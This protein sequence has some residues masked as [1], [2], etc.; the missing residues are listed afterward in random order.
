MPELTINDIDQI[1]RY[2]RTQEI[3]FSHLP[4]D[5]IDHICCDVE[6][7]MQN[8]IDFTEAY[9]RVREKMGK[10][11]LKE[12]QEETLYAVDTKYRQ[13]K[14]TMKIT[15]IAGTVLLG[16][17]ALFKIQHWPLAG[18]MLTLGAFT[19]A[20]F[21][22]PSA[23]GVLW[24][25]S[26]SRKKL[27]LF[28]SAFLAGMF[29]ILGTLFK[30]QHWPGAGI[31]IAMAALFGMFFFVP[32]LLAS[33][34][35][36][37]ENKSKK[38]VY[39]LGAVGIFCYAGGMLCKIQHWP[40]AG[41][42]L[43][44]GMIILCVIVFPWYTWISWK[45]ERHIS[46]KFLYMVI[47]VLAIMIP[48]ALINLN[49]QRNYEEGFYSHQAQQKAL[50]T[51]LYKYNNSLMIRYH[52]SLYYPQMEQLHAK[53]VSL[54][55]LIGDIQTKMV[56]ESEGEPGKPAVSTDQIS[57]TETGI[58]I[59][60]N[61]LSNPFQKVPVSDFLIPGGRSRVELNSAFAEYAKY[62]SD[63]LP[64]EDLQKYTS[65]LEPSVYIPGTIPDRTNIS[66]M[67]G[68]HT[69]ELLKNSILTVE[70]NTLKAVANH[71]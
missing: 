5:L 63:L 59:Q 18:V 44:L 57:K 49:L 68:L 8:G 58:E 67:S 31:I 11:R 26:Q 12:I 71:K 3:T 24:K 28:I 34:L 41:T 48:G 13:M 10:R 36:D 46:A 32:A 37:L 64:G 27:F 70:S 60:Y 33:K 56:Q 14:N 55:T 29:F 43:V 1:S 30:I 7:E 40:L 51:S 38:P 20:F 47:G 22:M 25:E 62:I 53:T 4:D 54:L 52:D 16:F 61:M 65:L 17:A 9:H 21:F 42:L 15:G 45:E 19:L 66:L 35:R 69:L 50:Y 2:V 6:N 23:L 39:I